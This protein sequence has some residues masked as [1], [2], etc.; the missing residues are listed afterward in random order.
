VLTG[1]AV[2]PAA[3]RPAGRRGGRRR[4]ARI[5]YRLSEAARV[6]FRVQRRQPG[7]RR[8][9]RC[10]PASRAKGGRRC[11]RLRAVRGGLERAGRAGRNAVRFNG[12]LRRRALKPGRYVLVATPL[13]ADGRPGVTRRARFRIVR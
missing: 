13:A 5:V 3:F 2:R 7:R 6:R 8:G 10:L 12:R 11:V 9:G 4:G 1:L